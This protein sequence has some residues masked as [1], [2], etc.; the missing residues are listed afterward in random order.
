MA[1][2][3]HIHNDILVFICMYF[4]IQGDNIFTHTQLYCY[5]CEYARQYNV[6]LVRYRCVYLYT[7]QYNH[8][9]L[10]IS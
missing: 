3:K 2:Y 9:I 5:A 1:I 7:Q 4:H 6:P 8:F 10:F